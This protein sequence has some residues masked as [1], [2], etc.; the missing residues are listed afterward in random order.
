MPN[1][2]RINVTLRR[3]GVVAGETNG[4]GLRNYA[5]IKYDPD[6]ILDYRTV[7]HEM[8]HNLGLLHEH[9]RPDR[10]NYLTVNVTGSQFDK[11]EEKYARFLWWTWKTRSVTYSSTYDYMSIM[12]YRNSYYNPWF[13]DKNGGYINTGGTTISS[14][15]AEFIKLIYK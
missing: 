2:E 3:T 9:Q 7:V 11:I 5:W 15:D 1:I 14:T 8:G 13:S 10:D 4:C 6:Y 12:H